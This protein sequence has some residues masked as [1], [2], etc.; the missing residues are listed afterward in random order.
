[1]QRLL[2]AVGGIARVELR[3]R[4]P[5]VVRQ[6]GEKALELRERVVLVGGHVVHGARPGL[7]A[8]AAQLLLVGRL[9]HPRH[10]DDRRARHEQL[11]RALDDH[12]EVRADRA[13]RAETRHRPERRGRHRNDR[14]VLHDEVEAGQRRHVGEAH[15]L[16]RL[17]APAAARAVHEPDERQAQVVREALGVDGLLPDRGVRRAAAHGEVVALHDRAPPVDA[18]LAD[19]R[20]GRQELGQLAVVAVCPAAGER[21]GLVEAPLI[22]EPLDPLPNRQAPG[23]VLALDPLLAAHPPRELL[24]PAQLLELGL[25][26]HAGRLARGG[27]SPPRAR[28]AAVRGAPRRPSCLGGL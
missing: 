4:L 26:G 18:A 17:D 19:D 22:E 5:D 23:R 1:M 21:P 11:S 13:R 10:R 14:E 9:A 2:A 7:E 16:E 25:P 28:T 27:A 20:V 12:R 8:R 3:R 24:A 6:V 15:L